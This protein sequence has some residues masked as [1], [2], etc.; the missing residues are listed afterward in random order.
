MLKI[1]LVRILNAVVDVDYQWSNNC[2]ELLISAC[3]GRVAFL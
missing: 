1:L 3:Q 2:E